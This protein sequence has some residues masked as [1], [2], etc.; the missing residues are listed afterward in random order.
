[1][2]TNLLHPTVLYYLVILFRGAGGGPGGNETTW[3]DGGQAYVESVLTFTSSIP[4]TAWEEFVKR[5]ICMV[6][7]KQSTSPEASIRRTPHLPEDANADCSLALTLNTSKQFN[8]SLTHF[9]TKPFARFDGQVRL[10]LNLEIATV[11]GERVTA[12]QA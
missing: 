9:N 5:N 2:G 6:T 8:S 10:E 11:R 3:R 7:R 12:T 4:E 1:M